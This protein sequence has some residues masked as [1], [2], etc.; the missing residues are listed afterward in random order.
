MLWGK[1]KGWV[2][3]LDRLKEECT[4]LLSEEVAE[5]MRT[6]WRPEIPGKEKRT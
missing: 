1:P 3:E 4:Q 2:E 5:F 6:D